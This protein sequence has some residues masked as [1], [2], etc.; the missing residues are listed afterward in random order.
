MPKIIETIAANCQDCYRCVRVCPIGAIRVEGGQAR[1]DGTL[2]VQCGTCVREC[3]QH[4]KTIHKSLD[5]VKEWIEA[6]IPVAA[7]VAPSF[8]AVFEGW[9]ATRLPAALRLLGFSSVSETAEGAKAVAEV[10]KDLRGQ[11]SITTCCPAVVAY[12]EKYRPELVPL[13]MPVVSPMAAHGRILKARMGQGTKVVFIGPCAAKK[14][15]ALRPDIKDAVDAVLTYDELHAWMEE[16]AVNLVRCPESG[17]DT[18]GNPGNARLF[19][20]EGGLLKTA[21]IA[22]ELDDA[23]VLGVSGAQD[24]MDL[25]DTPVSQWTYDIVEPMFCRGGCIGG[26]CMP[27]E[28]NLFGATREVIAYAGQAFEMPEEPVTV[29]LDAAYVPNPAQEKLTDVSEATILQI[30][31][32]T[33]KGEMGKQLNCGACGYATC[34][35]NAIAVARGMAEPG[36]CVSYVRQKAERRADHIIENSPNGIVVVDTELNIVHMNARFMQMFDCAS[37]LIGQP[38]ARIVDPDGFEKLL[39]GATGTQESI[40]TREG[41]KYQA[42]IFTLPGE[43]ELTGIYVD[44]SQSTFDARQVDLIKDQSLKHAR[45]LLA[46]Q[47][48]FSQEMAHY[49][50]KSTAQTEELVRR[51]MD[52]Y[53][54][55]PTP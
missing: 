19:A 54:E 41:M 33:G 2:C 16:E 30:L 31:E 37:S 20:L 34:R 3:P 40:G 18:V 22:D 8:A 25:F 44:V 21:Q 46:H 12:I 28:V 4:A 10:S 5:Q 24:V 32:S 6:G 1:V 14:G 23:R 7:S 11:A 43:K 53:A 51:L 9:R 45:D 49:L 39:S 52:M 47:I 29:P 35:E 26:P 27:P 36:M 38:V 13:L 42:L 15:E 55:E 50:G 48:R 17:F